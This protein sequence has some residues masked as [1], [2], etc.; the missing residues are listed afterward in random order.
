[1]QAEKDRPAPANQI[2]PPLRF[3]LY[4]KLHD[5]K[6]NRESI[7]VHPI[8]RAILHY[9]QAHKGSRLNEIRKNVGHSSNA[10]RYHLMRL[11]DEGLLKA[12]RI[13]RYSRYCITPDGALAIE[14]LALLE[15]PFV[16]AILRRTQ[17][18]EMTLEALMQALDAD[19]RSL[20]ACLEMMVE[21]GLAYV[22]ANKSAIY[23]RCTPEG[24]RLLVVADG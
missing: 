24:R 16:A 4:R 3:K 22:D 21:A 9:V 10:V 12:E 1:M 20:V 14:G 13:A 23:V 11:V 6:R 18:K 2:L 17:R 7:L 8:R 5:D 19:H 15:E